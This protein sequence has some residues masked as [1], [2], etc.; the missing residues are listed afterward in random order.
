MSCL[1]DR[2]RLVEECRNLW[3]YREYPAASQRSAPSVMDAY[4]LRRSLLRQNDIRLLLYRCRRRTTI[5]PRPLCAG[6]RDAVAGAISNAKLADALADLTDVAEIAL[7][8]SRQP[9]R[10]ARS[11]CLIALSFDEV[12]IEWFGCNFIILSQKRTK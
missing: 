1:A 12:V 11:S 7:L 8:H 3:V 4:F 9:R 5:S 10:D 2:Q 6:S